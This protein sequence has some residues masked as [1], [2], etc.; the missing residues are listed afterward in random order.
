MSVMH[1]PDEH[2]PIANLIE[3]CAVYAAVLGDTLGYDSN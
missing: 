1:A 3:A 2:V